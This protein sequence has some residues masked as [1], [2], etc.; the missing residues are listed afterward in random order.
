MKFIAVVTQK[1]QIDQVVKQLEALG[2]TIERVLQLT[3]VITGDTG[4]R[5]IQELHVPGIHSIEPD[6]I[7]S[8]RKKKS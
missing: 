7:I 1:S 5:T 2:C 6:R 3:G 8:T 4:P